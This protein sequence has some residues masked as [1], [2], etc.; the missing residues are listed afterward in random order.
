MVDN[1]PTPPTSFGVVY[2]EGYV[3]AVI[4]DGVQAGQAV[5]AL[6]Q[7]GIA[8][9]DIVLLTGQEARAAAQA[10]QEH[11]GSLK[12]VFEDIFMDELTFQRDYLDQARVGHSI[13][14][15][16]AHPRSRARHPRPPRALPCTRREVL[17]ARDHN[18]PLK[19]CSVY[20]DPA[21]VLHTSPPP[22]RP[23]P[24]GLCPAPVGHVW[25][26]PLIVC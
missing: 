16:K 3:V 25:D 24:V 21:R 17:R 9:K 11:V 13:L 4:D 2:P 23:T 10:A 8:A 22:S 1:I 7:H 14:N 26:D 20:P 18:G 15:V 12:R 6:R 19:G 5:E